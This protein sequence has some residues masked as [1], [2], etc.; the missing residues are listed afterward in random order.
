MI[1][2]DEKKGKVIVETETE[3]KEYGI[4]TPEA[5]EIISNAWLRSGWDN[6]FY[7]DGTPCNSIAGRYD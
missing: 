4:G 5:F 2:I 7:M 6:K 1:K 3:V